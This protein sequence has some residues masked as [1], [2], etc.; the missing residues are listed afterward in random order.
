MAKYISFGG[1]NKLY[2]YIWFFFINK[3][4]NGY[5]FGSEF[6]NEIKIVKKNTLPKSLI[7]QEG[8]NYLGIFLFSIFL[9]IYESIQ[10]KK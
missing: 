4:I 5:L 6:P 9:L 2:K 1:Y 10:K 7:I 8:F 3:F